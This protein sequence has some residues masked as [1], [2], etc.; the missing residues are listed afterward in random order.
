MTGEI[1]VAVICAAAVV[2]SVVRA[3]LGQIALER[4]AAQ[5][6]AKPRA[7]SPPALPVYTPPTPAATSPLLCKVVRV[8]GDHVESLH[9][10]AELVSRRDARILFENAKLGPHRGVVQVIEHGK[11]RASVG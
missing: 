9:P 11:V 2:V 6:E 8:H 3:Q 5:L 1:V 7:I 10:G 4:R